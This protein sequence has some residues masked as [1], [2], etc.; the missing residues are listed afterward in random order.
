MFIYQMK[1]IKPSIS[2]IQL[3]DNNCFIILTL[4]DPNE[5]NTKEKH[6]FFNNILF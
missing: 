5:F 2:L 1:R 4:S 3:Y 6:I